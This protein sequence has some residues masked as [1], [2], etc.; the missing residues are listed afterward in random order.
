MDDGWWSEEDGEHYC[1]IRAN[2]DTLPISINEDVEEIMGEAVSEFPVELP[3]VIR[4]EFGGE[5]FHGES[6]LFEND[7]CYE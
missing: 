2:G 4:F 7:A 1:Y 3:E 6:L 5:V